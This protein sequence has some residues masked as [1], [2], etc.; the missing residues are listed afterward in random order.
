MVG[1]DPR[2]QHA[3]VAAAAAAARPL[4]VGGEGRVRGEDG[5]YSCVPCGAT[6]EGLHAIKSPFYD[7]EKNI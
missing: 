4:A 7:K 2:C 6:S 5:R 1:Y 3:A